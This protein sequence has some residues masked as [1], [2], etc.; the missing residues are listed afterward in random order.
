[1]KKAPIKRESEKLVRSLEISNPLGAALL[2]GTVVTKTNYLFLWVRIVTWSMLDIS[3]LQ[4]KLDL[5]PTKLDELYSH[6]LNRIDPI[7]S[8]QAS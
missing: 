6:M 8:A 4:R 5:L 7:H 1:L 2:A 3:D